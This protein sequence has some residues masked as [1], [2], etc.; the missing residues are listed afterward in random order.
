MYIHIQ[1]P[2]SEEKECRRGVVRKQTNKHWKDFSAAQECK[3][4]LVIQVKSLSDKDKN[5]TTAGRET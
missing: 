2:E 3:H 1:R 4:M 5:N